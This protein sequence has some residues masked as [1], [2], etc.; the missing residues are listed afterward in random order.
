MYLLLTVSIVFATLNNVALQ[1]P[2]KKDIGFNPFLFNVIVALVWFPI[3]FI[4]NGGIRNVTFNTCIYGLIYGFVFTGFIFFK[5]KAMSSG[6]ISL[7]ALIGCS[8]FVITTIFNAIYWKESIGFFEAAGIVV[9]LIAIIL[10][11]IDFKRNSRQKETSSLKW[12][13][14][15]L[16]FF[17]F[18]G[19]TGIIFRFHQNVD[20]E[21]TN[22]M[23]MIAAIISVLIFI[24]IWLIGGGLKKNDADEKPKF[25]WIILIVALICGVL[26]CVYNRLNIYLSGAMPSVLFFPIFNCSVILLSLCCGCIMYKEKLTIQKAVGVFLG[27]VAVS[28]I[29]RFFGTC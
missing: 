27:V 11:N 22:E 20:A 23:M 13:I 12:K 17:L 21:N 28:L 18:A 25:G 29:S 15:S 5:S 10:S 19:S 7:T 8:S 3:L 24:I 1:Y 14:Y 6:P 16:F 9:A 26:S 4:Y 2:T